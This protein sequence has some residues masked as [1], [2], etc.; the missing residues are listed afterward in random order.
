MKFPEH[1]R[2]GLGKISGLMA[3]GMGWI[4]ESQFGESKGSH[5]NIPPSQNN[6]TCAAV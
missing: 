3:V 4:L 1:A 6:A 5:P 2:Q